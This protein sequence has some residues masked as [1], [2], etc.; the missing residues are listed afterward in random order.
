MARTLPPE[1]I[2]LIVKACVK[3]YSL[4]FSRQRNWGIGEL[5]GL[6]E[7]ANLRLVSRFCCGEILQRCIEAFDGRFFVS[8]SSRHTFE[9][10]FQRYNP[11]M[12]WVLDRVTE[13]IPSIRHSIDVPHLN[14]TLFPNLKIVSLYLLSRIDFNFTPHTIESLAA[15]EE[16]QNVQSRASWYRR[17]IVELVEELVAAGKT[18]KVWIGV[19]STN[20]QLDFDVDITDPHDVKILSRSQWG[21][22]D[23]ARPSDQTSLRQDNKRSLIADGIEK[24]LHQTRGDHTP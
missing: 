18:V 2:S 7:T 8:V 17:N 15:G 13:V 16:D 22:F 10:F 1:I 21:P 3:P 24:N 23:R 5:T 11:R 6:P 9:I 4:S 20:G 12:Q 19:I 14:Y